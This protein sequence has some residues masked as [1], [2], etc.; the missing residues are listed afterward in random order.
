MVSACLDA[1]RVSGDERWTR[2][3]KSAFP[4]S[5]RNQLQYSPTIRLGAAVATG[6]IPIG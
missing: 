3:M 5:R 2:E 6:C 1:W 4:G